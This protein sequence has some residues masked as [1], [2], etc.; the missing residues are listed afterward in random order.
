[1]LR[2]STHGFTVMAAVAGIVSMVSCGSPASE[3][4]PDGAADVAT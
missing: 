4:D 3:T 2:I 1:M